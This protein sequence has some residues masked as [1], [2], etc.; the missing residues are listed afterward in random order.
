MDAFAGKSELGAKDSDRSKRPRRDRE[1]QIRGFADIA[2]LFEA[3]PPHALEAEM[4]V[5]GSMLWDPRVVGDVVTILRS[6]GDFYRPAHSA[7]YESMVEIYD[8]NGGL[9]LVTLNQRLV[10]KGLLD[11]VGGLDYLVA[12]AEGVPGASSAT[13]YARLVR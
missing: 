8:R 2:K 6:G 3:L 11:A 10:D 5:L 13:H 12:L 9:D 4:S 7:I 1:A